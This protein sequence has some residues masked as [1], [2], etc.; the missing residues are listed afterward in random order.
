MKYLAYILI[1]FTAMLIVFFIWAIY[2]GHLG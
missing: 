1:G 2:G